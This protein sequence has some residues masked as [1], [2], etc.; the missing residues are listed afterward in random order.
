MAKKSSRLPYRVGQWL[1]AD[2][3]TLERWLERTLK[4]A[5]EAAKPLE[6][7][8]QAL[9]DLIESDP[10]AYM[11]FHQMFNQVPRRAPYNM[12]PGG[13]P[14][15]RNYHQMLRL[16]NHQ[17]TTPPEYNDTGLIG[18]PINAILDWSMGTEAGFAAFL[19][20]K[21]NAA[22]KG[23][24]D[25]WGQYLLTPDSASV[26]N[27]DPDDGWLGAN[28]MVALVQ[29]LPEYALYRQQT[30]ED[31]EPEEATKIFQET[32]VCEPSE[33]HWGWKSWDDFFI[34]SFRDGKRDP[35]SP[36]D[37]DVIANACES[38]P[39]ALK[40]G[41]RERARFWMKGQPYSL[42]HMLNDDPRV[43]QFVGG[44][45]YQAFLSAKSYHCWNAP[46]SGKVVDIQLIPG[47]YYSE[48][49]AFGFVN[50]RMPSDSDNFPED[51]RD[52]IQ[53]PDSAAPNDS[54][55][56][57]SEMAARGLMFVEADNKDIGLM[58]FLAI[59]MAEVSAC[60]F[61]VKPGDHIAKGQQI[62]AFHFGG[63]T[64]CLIFRPEVKLEFDLHG[65][66]PSLDAYNIPVCSRIATVRR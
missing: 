65:Q 6:P 1:P 43:E 26:L 32:F 9:K 42:R 47:T 25:A 39:F 31:L 52:P 33:P 46:V 20:D 58:A 41:V 10:A 19:D 62:G 30:G 12:N 11:W 36:D 5:E 53:V 38:A 34:R 64:H 14:Q 51:G 59:G 48:P 66:V 37:D 57:I 15:V 50:P 2:Q 16:M 27:E 55:G 17:L 4:R 13:Q 23:V 56:Y 35:A 63:S 22:L 7:S 18:F 29:A 54:Q 40:F 28:A 3:H 8:V 21:V 49:P 24:L 60:D 61:W 44:T 45:V